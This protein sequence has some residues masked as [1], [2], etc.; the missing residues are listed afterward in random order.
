MFSFRRNASIDADTEQTK[1]LDVSCAVFAGVEQFEFDTLSTASLNMC[2]AA[3]NN[4]D[5]VTVPRP[6]RAVS[7]SLQR[8]INFRFGC[9][10][11]SQHLR[12]DISPFSARI[13]SQRSLG[14]A[15]LHLSIIF[16]RFSSRLRAERRI[17]NALV[18]A[19]SRFTC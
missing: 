8:T 16:A 12:A 17:E 2:G 5:G 7:L 3:I 18:A 10:V 9:R 15:A 4:S 13:L 19:D 14:I 1:N 6:V 11:H